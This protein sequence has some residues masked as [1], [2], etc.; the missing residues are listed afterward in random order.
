MLDE[1]V[2]VSSKSAVDTARELALQEG[3]LVG[4]SSGK[5]VT[6]IRAGEWVT[7]VRASS[8]KWVTHVWTQQE[9]WP[10]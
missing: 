3:L 6:H 4:I 7:H 10:C 5:W 1:V 8:G 9:S 2:R